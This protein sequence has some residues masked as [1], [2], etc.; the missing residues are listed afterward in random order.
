MGTHFRFRAGA[1]CG[2]DGERQF[3][4][5]VAAVAEGVVLARLNPGQL[6]RR[7][8]GR[9]VTDRDGRPQGAGRGPLGSAR[10]GPAPAESACQHGPGSQDG[11][12]CEP[13]RPALSLS[14]DVFADFR[15]Q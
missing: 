12:S 15:T 7:T 10:P 8:D 5:G 4:E 14:Q 11:L 3:H 13:R 2:V 6:G 9:L 1:A